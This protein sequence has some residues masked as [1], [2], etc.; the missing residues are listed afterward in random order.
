MA[1]PIYLPEDWDLFLANFS[2][3][4][5]PQVWEHPVSLF[6]EG[7][8]S[9]TSMIQNYDYGPDVDLTQSQLAQSH[10]HLPQ[11]DRGSGQE[12]PLPYNNHAM[13]P[14]SIIMYLQLV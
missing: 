6:D 7:I 8:D 11:V 10:V 9:N 3:L 5:H 2:L 12:P 1:T 13:I 4:D 14:V